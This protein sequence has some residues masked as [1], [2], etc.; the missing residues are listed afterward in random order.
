MYSLTFKFCTAVQL[1][2]QLIL[3]ELLLHNVTL[4]IIKIGAENAKV[5]V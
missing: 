3:F 5:V 4:N 2:R 1:G